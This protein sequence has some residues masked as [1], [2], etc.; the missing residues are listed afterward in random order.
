MA[1]QHLSLQDLSRQALIVGTTRFT[2]TTGHTGYS[3]E[4]LQVSA[5]VRIADALELQAQQQAEPNPLTLAE[6]GE[7][8]VLLRQESPRLIAALLVE[9]SEDSDKLVRLCELV[10]KLLSGIDGGQRNG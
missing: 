10:E 2:E 6:Y 8:H 9:G 4:S 1:K 7:L 3:N 5:L